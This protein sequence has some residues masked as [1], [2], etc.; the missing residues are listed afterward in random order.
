MFDSFSKRATEVVFAARFKAGERGANMI[1]IDDL[2]VGL[3][4][5]DQ[6]TL[7]KAIFPTI[8][9]GRVPPTRLRLVFSFSHRK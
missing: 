8:F 3:V 1:D 7:Q 9:E 5:E 6:G 4:L 2:L